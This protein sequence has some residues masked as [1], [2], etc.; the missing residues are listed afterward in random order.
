MPLYRLFRN[1]VQQEVHM[2]FAVT[3]KKFINPDRSPC[4]LEISKMAD[5]TANFMTR[6]NLDKIV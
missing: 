1:V 2:F 6:L 3:A 4:G 5:F